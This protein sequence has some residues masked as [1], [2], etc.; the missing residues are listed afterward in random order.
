MAG[1]K[2]PV[3]VVMEAF[4]EYKRVNDENQKQHR[5]DLDAKLAKIDEVFDKYEP[6]NQQMTLVVKQTTAM[7]EQFDNAIKVMQRPGGLLADTTALERKEYLAAFERVV[8]HA[9]DQRDP[10]DVALIN[11]RMNALTTGNDVGA[12]YLLAPAEMQAEIIKNIVEMSPMRSLATVRTIGSGSLK[13]PK[14]T[15]SGAA[16]RVGEKQTR[17]NTGDPAFG[18]VEIHAPE[19][20]ARVEVSQQMLEDSEYDLL[21]ELREDSSEQ[22]AVREGSE[23]I[24][25]VG[26]ANQCEGILVNAD[27]GFSVSGDANV[28]KSDGLIDLYYG[29]KTA[30]ARN[31]VFI[32]NRK[33]IASV[34]KLKD[35]QNQYLWQPGIA[36]N[37]PNTILGSPYVE[38]PDMPDVAANAFPIAFGDFK[39]AYVIVDRIALSFQVD[40]TTGADNGLVIFR[41]RKRTGGGVRQAEAIRKLKIST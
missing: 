30:Y 6:L 36:G 18:M 2:D 28:V 8:R 33:T 1:E 40:Y 34:R 17:T 21:A 38:M 4:N 19:M 26:A 3:T 31:G 20:F 13:Q 11:K 7:Q 41:G 14:K 15:G 29:I 23:H 22:F 37:V 39:R 10:A 9:P 5:A 16:S 35:S 12:G 32:L 27:V 24:N 25:G